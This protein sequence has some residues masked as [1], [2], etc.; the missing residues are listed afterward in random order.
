MGS[1]QFWCTEALREEASPC[2]CQ[3]NL[4]IE[5]GTCPGNLWKPL[6][7]NMGF[8]NGLKV[9]LW[10]CSILVCSYGISYW[11]ILKHSRFFLDDLEPNLIQFGFWIFCTWDARCCGLPSRCL[12]ARATWLLKRCRCISWSPFLCQRYKSHMATSFPFSLYILYAHAHTL[13]VYIYIYIVHYIVLKKRS[14]YI[15][16]III[17]YLQW[18]YRYT[19]TMASK[20]DSLAFEAV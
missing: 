6:E 1:R 2:E 15:C 10:K 14:C 12:H 16:S 5:L 20:V 19:Y 17:V 18:F 8:N 7:R 3:A 11:N 9:S 13:Y 4:L